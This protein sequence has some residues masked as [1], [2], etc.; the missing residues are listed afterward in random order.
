MEKQIGKKIDDK[1][2]VETVLES[3]DKWIAIENFMRKVTDAKAKYE[4]DILD[5]NKRV[6]L[7]N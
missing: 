6:I 2:L 4:T 5:K 1:N 3:K 7:D